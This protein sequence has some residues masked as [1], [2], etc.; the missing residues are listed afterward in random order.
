MLKFS[1][2]FS[3]KFPFHLTFIP[4]FPEF[5]VE[6]IFGNFSQEISVPFVPVSKISKFLV[7]WYAPIVSVVGARAEVSSFWTLSLAFKDSN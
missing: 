1:I 5:S 6:W 2:F 7:E 3:W 4:K